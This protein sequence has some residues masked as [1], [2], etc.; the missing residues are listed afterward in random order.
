MLFQMTSVIFSYI[1]AIG[2]YSGGRY[3]GLWFLEMCV[4]L[5]LNI[6]A[7]AAVAAVFSVQIFR[8]F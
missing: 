3:G 7:A 2:T 4:L 5:I 6:A 8:R 1:Y